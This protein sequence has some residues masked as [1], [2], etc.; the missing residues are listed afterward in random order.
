MDMGIME[1]RRLGDESNSTLENFHSK[2]VPL[3][4]FLRRKA[5]KHQKE[6]L[7]VTY[8]L[9]F[10]DEIVGYYSLSADTILATE[11]ELTKFTKGKTYKTYPAIKI[12]RLAIAEKYCGQNI[13]SWLLDAVKFKYANEPQS[14]GIRYLVVDSLAGSTGFYEKNKFQYWTENDS[15]EK[16]RLMYFDLKSARML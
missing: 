12:G 2:D 6:M 8:L 5:K 13:G 14:I 16:T 11:K 4:N 10:K 7:S 15:D 1:I 3:N 9:Y